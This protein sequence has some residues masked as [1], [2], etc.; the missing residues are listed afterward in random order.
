MLVEVA[1][2]HLH[3][4]VCVDVFLEP[5]KHSRRLIV[6]RQCIYNPKAQTS[7]DYYYCLP[8]FMQ[9][10][11]SSSYWAGGIRRSCLDL[12]GSICGLY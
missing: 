3:L 1:F 8:L 7:R 10:S 4:L 12:G 2:S 11:N 5:E 6:V 9:L